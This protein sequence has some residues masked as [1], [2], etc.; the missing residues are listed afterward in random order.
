MQQLNKFITIQNLRK[1]VAVAF[2]LSL[3]IMFRGLFYKQQVW[4]LHELF[5][6]HITCLISIGVFF[7]SMIIILFRPTYGASLFS[8]AA[9]AWFIAHD[10]NRYHPMM[11]AGLALLAVNFEKQ[12]DFRS[13]IRWLIIIILTFMTVNRINSTNEYSISMHFISTNISLSSVSWLLYLIV[14][15][16][17]TAILALVSFPY[18]KTGFIMVTILFG[19]QAGLSIVAGDWQST[20]WFIL[21]GILSFSCVALDGK[22]ES[23]AWERYASLLV[24]VLLTT[25]SYMGIIN[26]VL[27]FPYYSGRE[28]DGVLLFNPDRIKNAPQ[29]MHG[30]V[31]EH[32]DYGNDPLLYLGHFTRSY[33][34]QWL[35]PSKENILN[36]LVPLRQCELTEQDVILILS[37]GNHR[38]E[39]AGITPYLIT[40]FK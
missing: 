33:Y 1:V 28:E 22:K 34:G 16:N 26:K 30:Y 40:D 6:S 4:P 15:F 38:D 17:A 29:Q 21:V 10:L 27:S 35:Y 31:Y 37:S 3:L 8:I 20:L 9:F 14:A 11:M 25:L 2:V 19:I 32:K 13:I 24:V 12:Y 23:F 39:M 18:R 7:L 36:Q 5:S